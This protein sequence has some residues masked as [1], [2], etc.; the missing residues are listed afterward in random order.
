MVISTQYVEIPVTAEWQDY[1][2]IRVLHKDTYTCYFNN[3]ILLY[4]QS[5][6]KHHLPCWIPALNTTTT[7]IQV[8]NLD[9]MILVDL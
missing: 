9:N 6:I 5:Y 2:K 1:H 7:I 3:N 4:T 8:H